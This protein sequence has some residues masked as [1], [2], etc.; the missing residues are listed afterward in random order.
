MSRTNC[1]SQIADTG[2]EGRWTAGAEVRFSAAEHA[3]KDRFNVLHVMLDV[4]QS[5][6]LLLAQMLCDLVVF[7]KQG[8]KISLCL[9]RTHGVALDQP[10]S[11]LARKPLLGERKH[12]ALR[13]HQTAK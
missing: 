12:H 6:Q 10:V 4:E 11:V 1:G 7:L 3:L 5:G 8:C 2:R 13:V 9:P